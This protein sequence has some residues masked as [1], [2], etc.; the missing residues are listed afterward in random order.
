MC[1]CHNVRITKKST[2]PLPDILRHS[3]LVIGCEEVVQYSTT[4]QVYTVSSPVNET[5]PSKV[6]AALEFKTIQ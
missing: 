5:V 6:C 1:G 2:K 4:A 3:K